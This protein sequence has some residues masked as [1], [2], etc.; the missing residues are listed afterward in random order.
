MSSGRPPIVDRLRQATSA[1]HAEVEEAADVM[2]GGRER[3]VWFVGKQLGFLEPLERRLAGAPG[4]AE[5]GID[6]SRRERAHLFAADL[7][8]LGAHPA[9]APRCAALP[10]VDSAARALGALYVLE[11][12]TLGGIFLLHQ[13]GRALGVTAASGASGIAPYGAAVRDMWVAYADALDRFVQAHPA[14]EAE[15]VDAARD[16]FRAM[17]A[18][19]REPEPATAAA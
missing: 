5:A 10:R 3:Y 1:L 8:E 15:I 13:V 14:E 19:L 7:L 12:S 2:S 18:W 4:L 16:T 9:R 11:G 17:L 6:L